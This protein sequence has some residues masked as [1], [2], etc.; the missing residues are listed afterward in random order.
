MIYTQ[1]LLNF[2]VGEEDNGWLVYKLKKCTKSFIFYFWKDEVYN[3]QGIISFLK[4][5]KPSYKRTILFFI[6]RVYF[7]KPK[8]I[9]YHISYFLYRKNKKLKLFFA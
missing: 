1:F 4:Y 8:Q 9:E 7:H 3:K 6:W 2:G 5:L